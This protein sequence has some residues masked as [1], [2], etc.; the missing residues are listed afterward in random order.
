MY[1]LRS[2]AGRLQ[3]CHGRSTVRFVAAEV[4][5]GHVDCAG[6]AINLEQVTSRKDPAANTIEN[7]EFSMELHKQTVSDVRGP[8]C[9]GGGG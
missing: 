7:Q 1:I 8:S 6:L 9:G 2:G 3:F 4:V 5:A